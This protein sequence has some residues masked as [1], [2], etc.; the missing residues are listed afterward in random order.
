ME[1]ERISVV[2]RPRVTREAVDLG[3]AMLRAN[4]RA[5]WSAWFAF[6]L[7]AFVLCNALGLLLDLP[8]LGWVLVWWLKPLFDRVP[9]YVLSRA[10]FDRAPGWRETLRGQRQ[11][12]WRSTLAGLTW[13][14]IDSSRALRLPLDLLEGATR[15]QRSARWK[16]LRKRIVGDVSLLTYGCLQ[17]ELV[18]FLSFWMFAWLLIPDEWRPESLGELFR[19]G[20]QG[21]STIW[22][23]LGAGVAYLAMSAIE[24]LYVACGFALYLN[25]RTQLEAWDI[26]L[27]F[28]RM[29]TRIE[30][31]GKVLGVLLCLGML[32][33]LHAQASPRAQASVSAPEKPIATSVGQVFG[34]PPAGDGKRFAEAAA[35]A[36]RDPRFGGEHTTRGWRLKHPWQAERQQ[37]EMPFPALGQWLSAIFKGLLWLLLG[38]A[39]VTLGWFAWRWR[40]RWQAEPEEP[41]AMT[42]SSLLPGDAAELPLPDDLAAATRA[43]WQ[44]QRRREALALLYRGCVEHTAQLLQLP[45][46]KDATE[47]DWLHRAGAIEDAAR[48]Q[49]VVAIVRTWQFAA[50]AGRYPDDATIEQLLTGWPAQAGAPA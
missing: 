29:R 21:V 3:A 8:W 18:L 33:S 7:P 35:Q 32:P 25:R 48:A 28:R 38:A 6:T 34:T 22:I 4:A 20:T 16:V 41:A 14:R 11:W 44:T 46:S 19:G 39:L 27:A 5:V 49:R 23:V 37:R 9:L 2:L 50:Y 36:Y 24:P 43:L 12:S 45:P 26:D 15:Q 31:L 17:F 42:S 1:L 30:A 47:S 10:V 40:G 13:L